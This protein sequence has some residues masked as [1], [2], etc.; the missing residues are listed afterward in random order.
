MHTRF[1]S[2]VLV[3]IAAL[4]AVIAVAPARA[5]TTTNTTSWDFATGLR[6]TPGTPIEVARITIEEPGGLC[7]VEMTA[8]NGQSEH[9]GN[10]LIVEHDG[11]EVLMLEGVE[12]EPFTTT[13]GSVTIDG[14]SG[15]V[16]VYLEPTQ[17][18]RTSI[19][20][21]LDVMCITQ[22]PTTTTEPPGSTTTTEPPG[23][24]TTTEPPGS[25]TTTEPPGST[26]TTEPPPVTTTT[27]DPGDPEAPPTGSTPPAPGSHE[28]PGGEPGTL[29]GL[30]AIAGL[31]G[32]AV[33]FRRDRAG[34]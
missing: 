17:A 24:T 12:D 20:G 7:T 22:P 25:T 26:T 5:D 13:T 18:H 34:L 16:V 4:S 3:A 8:T 29:Y 2:A 9:P 15:A 19:A 28:E 14:A 31:V 33:L 32:S 30:L 23:S 21:R 11:V 6:V 27:T 1:F 10:N